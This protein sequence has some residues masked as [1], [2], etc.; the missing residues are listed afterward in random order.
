MVLGTKINYGGVVALFLFCV[1]C[2][3]TNNVSDSVEY[4]Q[5]SFVLTTSGGQCK[6]Q[7]T[8][9]KSV[10]N[11]PLELSAPCHFV[12]KG[13]K[14]L[15][16][17]PYKD[18]DIEAT[19]VIVGNPITPEVRKEWG[20]EKNVICGEKAQG[21]LINKDGVRLSKKALDGGVM[22]PYVGLDEKDFWYLAH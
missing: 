3:A 2:N 20:L 8:I 10:Y 16:H 19:L 1:S 13:D 22:C 18:V 5:H 7:H 14:K 12:R 15:R 21:L 9:D 6:L 4:N 11:I 17:F